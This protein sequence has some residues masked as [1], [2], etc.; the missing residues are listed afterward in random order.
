VLAIVLASYTMIVLDISMVITALPKIHDALG[1]SS[2][3]PAHPP[4]VANAT[5]LAYGR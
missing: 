4:Q 2:T 3:R 1:F 5:R